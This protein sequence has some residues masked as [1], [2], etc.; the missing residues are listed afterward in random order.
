LVAD[1]SLD[2]GLILD[3]AKY[4]IEQLSDV[5]SFTIQGV[6]AQDGAGNLML[7]VDYHIPFILKKFAAAGAYSDNEY[8]DEPAQLFRIDSP[9]LKQY[10]SDIEPDKLL[11]AG[12]EKEISNKELNRSK[13][14]K[15]GKPDRL[16]IVVDLHINKLVDHVIGL[17]NHE[18]LDIQMTR[19]RKELDAAIIENES[20]I[21]FIHGIGNGTLKN[22][23][24][25]SVDKDYSFCHYE[26]ASF[27][28]YGYGATR[29]LIRQNKP[30]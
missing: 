9:D 3:L 18:I 12:I 4:D 6:L 8:L 14:F 7:P 25:N 22:E 29:V 16:P 26:D 1:E 27:R 19:F 10:I 5:E 30:L 2:A 23:L 28:Q 11:A 17:G 15:S 24:R 20:E 13:E 21:I